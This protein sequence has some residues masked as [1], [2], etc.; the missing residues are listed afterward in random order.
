MNTEKDV[1]EYKEL[2]PKKKKMQTNTVISFTSR[3]CVCGVR[4]FLHSG[5]M[6][7]CTMV[8]AEL[9]IRLS[10]VDTISMSISNMKIPINE[11]GRTWRMKIGIRS[12]L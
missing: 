12:W 10:S 8:M 7:S 3:I 11:P 1:N 4:G 2:E 9:K 5:T 6:M